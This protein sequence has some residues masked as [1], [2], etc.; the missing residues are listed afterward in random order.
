ML[1]SPAAPRRSRAALV[2]LAA[3]L[4]LLT[5][6]PAT[7]LA[8]E[9]PPD[10]VTDA[11][12][13]VVVSDPS[14]SGAPLDGMTVTLRALRADLV[15]DPVIQ[16]LTG[17]TDADGRLI[18]DGVARPADGA[19]PVALHAA[20]EIEV[21][22]DCGSQ[23]WSGSGTAAAA[24]A[25]DL[26]VIIDSS[27]AGCSQRRLDGRVVD[28]A[29]APFPVDL[30]EAVITASGGA[31]VSQPVDVDIDG[32]FTIWLGSVTAADDA[33]VRLT[34][35]SPVMTVPGAPGCDLQ[36]VERAIEEWDVPAGAALPEQ[37]VVAERVVLASTCGT[38]GTPGPD[39]PALT[40]PPTDGPIARTARPLSPMGVLVAV[41]GLLLV[42]AGV[43]AE[44]RRRRG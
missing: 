24:A 30:A 38:T 19:P 16:E 41:L 10:V 4:S 40:L 44:V 26:S 3:S 12:V 18:F 9:L 6:I 34:V 35:E 17:L 36:V 2:A 8:A 15:D 39:A 27:T 7:S 5:A 25:V 14:A 31:P 20:A 23:R 37:V 22:T 13:T 21:A 11:T 32:A 1:R 28:A 29:G 43:T 42:A 33:V